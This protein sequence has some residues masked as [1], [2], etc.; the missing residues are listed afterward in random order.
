MGIPATYTPCKI[1]LSLRLLFA[2]KG[3]LITISLVL[4]QTNGKGEKSSFFPF[5][6][7]EH[8]AGSV[9]SDEESNKQTHALKL[10]EL[11]RSVAGTTLIVIDRLLNS[12]RCEF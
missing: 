12:R 1:F 4:Y 5:F 6:A 2:A 10:R 11:F 3:K 8:I 9:N 7:D